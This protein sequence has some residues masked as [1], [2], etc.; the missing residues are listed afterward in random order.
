[1]KAVLLKLFPTW[2]DS[3]QNIIYWSDLSLPIVFKCHLYHVL[4]LTIHLA[5][6]M[7]LSFTVPKSVLITALFFLAIITV[8]LHQKK[9]KNP[10]GIQQSA[11]NLMNLGLA[12]AWAKVGWAWPASCASGGST[13]RGCP[14]HCMVVEMLCSL[15]HSSSCD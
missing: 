11:F 13:R 1:M 3:C 6:S 8:M 7:H 5:L 15:C 4:R 14:P 12:W 10:T 2:I 9:T